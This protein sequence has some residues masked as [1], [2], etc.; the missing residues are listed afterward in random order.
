MAFALFSF[1]V[2]FVAAVC[3]VLLYRRLQALLQ[4]ALQDMRSEISRVVRY[5]HADV[6]IT[7]AAEAAGYRKTVALLKERGIARTGWGSYDRR[8]GDREPSPAIV[9]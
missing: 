9:A 5:N 1:L 6:L 7:K 2:A 4:A 3:A 8:H